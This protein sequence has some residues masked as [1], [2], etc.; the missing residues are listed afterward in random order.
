MKAR[1]AQRLAAAGIAAY[2]VF[3]FGAVCKKILTVSDHL[4]LRPPS[5]ISCDQ[6]KFTLHSSSEQ[7]SSFHFPF[8]NQKLSFLEQFLL[9]FSFC[10]FFLVLATVMYCLVLD[11]T[12]KV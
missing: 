12:G 5:I 8:E 4:G 9:A 2:L 3:R 7:V 10:L 11:L 1:F 6:N